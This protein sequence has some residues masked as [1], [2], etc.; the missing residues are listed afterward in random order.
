MA[1]LQQPEHRPDWIHAHYADAGYVGTGWVGVWEFPLF[2]AIR[3]A[4]KS[5]RLLACGGDH[6]QIEQAFSISR[7][8]DAEELALPMPIW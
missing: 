2:T 7:R 6:D 4:A 3:W 5:C 8:I 1:R